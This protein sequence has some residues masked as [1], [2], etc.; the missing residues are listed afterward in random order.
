MATSLGA[1]TTSP[2]GAPATDVPAEIA[3]SDVTALAR[4][5]WA[6]ALRGV[7]A[8]LFGLL[9]FLRPGATLAAFVLLF[10]LYA[11]VDGALYVVAALRQRH[12]STERRRHWGMLLAAGVTGIA[13][14]GLTLWYPGATALF[15]LYTVAGW[16]LVT[17]VSEIV[18]AVQ[19]R[20]AI[21]GEWLLALSG[22][23]SVLFGLLLVVA[24]GAGALALALWVAAYAVAAGL[25]LLARAFRLR[26]FARRHAGVARA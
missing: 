23:L 25:V 13:V 3:S 12:A 26:G 14:G 21:T 5:W 19:L 11:L 16:A 10:G 24:P 8:L 22:V 17:G 15:L 2:S 20:K 1:G 7:V 9:T 6:L 4:R 18:A